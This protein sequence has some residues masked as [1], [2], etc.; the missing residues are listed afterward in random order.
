MIG[1]FILFSRYLHVEAVEFLGEAEAAAVECAERLANIKRGENFNVI[2]I[3]TDLSSV[4]LLHYPDFFNQA[5]PELAA[6]W[7]IDLADSQQVTAHESCSLSQSVVAFAMPDS[8]IGFTR[9]LVDVIANIPSDAAIYD[10]QLDDAEFR[11]LASALVQLSTA[12]IYISPGRI[13]RIDD[14]C[15][16]AKQQLEKYRAGLI[17]VNSVTKI[18]DDEYKVADKQQSL[19]RLKQLAIELAVPVVALYQLDPTVE[20]HPATLTRNELKEIEVLARLTDRFLLLSGTTDNLVLSLPKIP[21]H[22]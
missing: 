15:L 4:S 11:R 6:S 13:V 9:K 18:V 8:S 3:S 20:N 1:K 10:G 21:V 14:L 16:S 2:R 22:A 5:F 19:I 12:H 7:R 17:L